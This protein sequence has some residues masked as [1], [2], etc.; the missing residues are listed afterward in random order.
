MGLSQI[1]GA[2][3]ASRKGLQLER[4]HTI[5]LQKTSCKDHLVTDSAAAAAAMARGIKADKNTFGTNDKSKA[6][7]S[8]LEQMKAHGAA[9]GMVVTCSVTHATPAA[10]VT[11]TEQRS[12]YE[13]IATDYM[14]VDIDYL[15]GGGKEYFDRRSNDDRNLIEE[16]KK[17][18]VIVKSYLDGEISDI[19]ITP[20]R[21]FVYF[22]ADSEPLSHSAGRTYFQTACERGLVYLSRKSGKGF[23]MMI[24]GSQIDWAGHANEADW[25]MQ[26]VLDFDKV[27]ARVLEFAEQDGNT[28]V[29]V[30]ADH[31]TGGL[32]LTSEDYENID[33]SFSTGGHT[34]LHVPVF[35]FGPSGEKFVGIYDNTEIARRLFSIWGKPIQDQ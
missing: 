16:L 19:N 20:Q 18:D 5:G 4:F 33:Y 17:K 6:P 24:E 1:S 12:M 3:Y 34:A 30:T 9:V 21:R 26:E 14:N 2:M 13:E 8:I 22:T 32:T 7:P 28:L 15:V 25:M 11:Y 10:F 35:G 23:F 27:I 29:L 31:E